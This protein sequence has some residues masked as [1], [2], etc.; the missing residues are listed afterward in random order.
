[1]DKKQDK[2][3]VIFDMPSTY[4]KY[5]VVCQYGYHYLV[6]YAWWGYLEVELNRKRFPWSKPKSKWIE[7]EQCWWSKEIK[8]ME[9]LKEAATKLYDEN[10]EMPIRMRETAINL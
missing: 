6:N 3:E 4:G 1:M 9:Q 5:R 8:T 7:V 2:R 10:I